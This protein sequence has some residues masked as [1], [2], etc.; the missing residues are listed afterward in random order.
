MQI[1]TSN[2]LWCGHARPLALIVVPKYVRC[3]ACGSRLPLNIDVLP[4]MHLVLP[5]PDD[6][7]QFWNEGES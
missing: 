2:C 5:A 4:P 3:P 1:V 7:G 6:W